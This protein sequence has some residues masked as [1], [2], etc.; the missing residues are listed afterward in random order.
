MAEFDFLDN[1]YDFNIVYISILNYISSYFSS[2]TNRIKVSVLISQF[3]SNRSTYFEKV[4]DV[5]K[6]SSCG[7]LIVVQIIT[8]LPP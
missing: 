6:G 3:L 7:S 8:N 5:G 4:D 1:C 2:A